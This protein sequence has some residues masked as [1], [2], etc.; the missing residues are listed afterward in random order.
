MFRDGYFYLTFSVFN[1]LFLLQRY[2]KMSNKTGQDLSSW[3]KALRQQERKMRDFQLAEELEIPGFSHREQKRLVREVLSKDFTKKVKVLEPEV[4]SVVEMV[5]DKDQDPIS[6]CFGFARAGEGSPPSLAETP[7]T[8]FQIPEVSTS[9]SLSAF[10]SARPPTGV[11]SMDQWS[12]VSRQL[13]EEEVRESTS[14]LYHLHWNNFASFCGDRGVE[15]T[16]AGPLAVVDFLA[17]LA[18]KSKSKSPALMARA[19]ISHCHLLEAPV[20]GDPT[21]HFVVPKVINSIV[22]KYSK[23]VKKAA[24]LS[25]REI[26]KVVSKLSEVPSVKD[27]RTVV[28]TLLQFSLMLLQQHHAVEDQGAGVFDLW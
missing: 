21:K 28:M 17:M 5:S 22:K 11:S 2:F 7:S 20:G 16:A 1:F 12:E 8:S 14:K 23:P 10:N 18:N 27:F 15:P 9:A 4:G 13:L 19:A 6:P 25:S 24:T 3:A 26:F